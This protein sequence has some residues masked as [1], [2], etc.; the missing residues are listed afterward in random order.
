FASI[1][2]SYRVFQR[3]FGEVILSALIILGIAIVGGLLTLILQFIIVGVSAFDI[4]T[5]PNPFR[6]L[7]G[8]IVTMPIQVGLQLVAL[9]TLVFR[10]LH[11]IKRPPTDNGRM[12]AMAGPDVNNHAP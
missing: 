7:L 4:N 10:Y 5:E 9:F 1:A 2:E 8:S 3:K 6:S 11:V 12:P